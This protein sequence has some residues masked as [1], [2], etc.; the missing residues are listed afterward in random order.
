MENL[1]ENFSPEKQ[2]RCQN[3]NTF[4]F[5]EYYPEQQY[6]IHGA[7][8][9]SVTGVWRPSQWQK[10]GSSMSGH[11]LYLEEVGPY[12]HIQDD[13]PVYYR[14]L[15]SAEEYE[16]CKGHFAGVSTFSS[17]TVYRAGT[18]KFTATGRTVTVK[19]VLTVDEYNAKFGANYD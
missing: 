12:D 7:H 6:P 3:G 19:D 9:D 17:P 14:K 15:E 1:I 13:Q 16:Y 18:S 2:Y 4:K 10:D 5:Y 11:T 8:K